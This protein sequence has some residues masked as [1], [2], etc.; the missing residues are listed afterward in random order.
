MI[1]V[2]VKEQGQ[3]SDYHMENVF[4]STSR[5]VAEIRLNILRA[6]ENR[7]RQAG[8]EMAAYLEK[9][10]EQTPYPEDPGI[11]YNATN[12]QLPIMK[13]YY[14]ARDVISDKRQTLYDRKAVEL[15]AKYEIG[16]PK[17]I[18]FS[19]SPDYDKVDY[20]IQEIESD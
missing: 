11:P 8:K 6:E 10:E 19:Y 5:E 12:C 18:R 15:A 13:A 16:D 14:A 3:Y 7:I 20:S 9:V 2:V 17:S 1:Y 4:A